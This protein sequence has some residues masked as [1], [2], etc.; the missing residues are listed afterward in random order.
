MAIGLTVFLNGCGDKAFDVQ[1]IE[2]LTRADQVVLAGY[3]MPVQVRA[4]D[5]D[6]FGRPDLEVTFAVTSGGGFVDSSV[7]MT[8]QDGIATTYW[9]LGTSGQQTLEATSNYGNGNAIDGSPL[10]F[11]ADVV[12]TGSFTDPRDNETYATVSIGGQTWMAENLRYA[13]AVSW[14]NPTSPSIYGRFY[15]WSVAQTACPQGWHLPTDEEWNT[16]EANMGCTGIYG[17]VND[18][19][20]RGDHGEGMK[21]NTGW[22]DGGNGNNQTGFNVHP[23]GVYLLADGLVY[24]TGVLGQFWTATTSPDTNYPEEAWTREFNYQGS[25]VTRQWEFRKKWNGRSCRCVQD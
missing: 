2:R 17:N 9:T 8:D 19:L 21:S 11:N 10:A 24:D 23:A 16:L 6:G 5:T 12:T 13:S 7:V 25:G 14:V 1:R 4:I 18:V 22:L 15:S 20:T 3:R